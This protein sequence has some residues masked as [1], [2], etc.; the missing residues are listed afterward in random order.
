MKRWLSMGLT[1]ALVIGVVACTKNEPQK[2]EPPKENANTVVDYGKQYSALYNDYI[3]TLGNYS[4]YT[5]PGA[6]IEY[7]NTNEYPGNEKYVEYLK[8]TYMDSKEKIQ[9]FV[10]G[11]KN[12]LKTEDKD[13]AKLSENLIAEGEKTI[14]N[15]DARL[16]KLEKL[17]KD[18]YGKTKD[19]FIN[20]VDEATKLEESAKS[21]F[22]K[23]LEDM[24]KQLNINLDN[25]QPN[26]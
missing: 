3:G 16:A 12:D 20:Y 8:T 22:D 17:P 4:V 13:V 26:K 11:L 24:K 23:M 2:Q 15:I 25:V 21:N 5:T 18:I 14:A 6:T 19:D 9:K 10:D 1:L 7:Y